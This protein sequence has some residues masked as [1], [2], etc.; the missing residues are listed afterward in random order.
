MFISSTSLLEMTTQRILLWF[1]TWAPAA[2]TISL[3]SL[4]NQNSGLYVTDAL[5]CCF[6]LDYVHLLQCRYCPTKTLNKIKAERM[7]NPA[8]ISYLLS[9]RIEHESHREELL[10]EAILPWLW[11]KP[12]FETRLDRRTK[13]YIDPGLTEDKLAS[14]RWRCPQHS[15][16]GF[17]RSVVEACRYVLNNR[18]LSTAQLD[19][20]QSVNCTLCARV[21]FPACTPCRS[22]HAYNP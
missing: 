8:F 1:A 11:E 20:L 19:H 5:F 6:C 4:P 13:K 10:Y 9:L 21:F 12:L 7:A 3:A 14:V 16:T 2:N 18:G 22:R 15:A 17:H